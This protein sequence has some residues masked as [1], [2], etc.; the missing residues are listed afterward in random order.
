[1]RM[2]TDSNGLALLKSCVQIEQTN[3]GI[4]VIIRWSQTLLVDRTL[5]SLLPQCVTLLQVELFSLAATVADCMTRAGAVTER[6][7]LVPPCRG[8]NTL[9]H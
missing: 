8:Q 6:R 3:L 4:K 5:Y 1:M 7:G 9:S 2:S